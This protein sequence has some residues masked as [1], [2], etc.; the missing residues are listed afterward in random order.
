VVSVKSVEARKE[1]EVSERKTLRRGKRKRTT[2]VK[3]H[4]GACESVQERVRGVDHRVGARQASKR[5]SAG[6][7]SATYAREHPCKGAQC[8]QC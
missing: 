4:L 2:V 5:R 8:D 6:E 1:D 3:N 7:E